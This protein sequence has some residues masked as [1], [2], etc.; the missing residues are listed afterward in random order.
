MKLYKKMP[1][2]VD[3]VI[4]TLYYHM[5]MNSLVS[6]VDSMYSNEIMNSVKYKEKK[7]NFINRIK[8]AEQKIFCICVDLYMIYFGNDYDEINKVLSTLKRK[9]LKI[10][11]TLTE[12]YKDLLKNPS[13]EQDYWS[14]TDQ[15]V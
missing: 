1:N 14:R 15:G 3:I 13:F 9:K 4:E 6:H 8:Y 10:K 11:N 2:F 12:Q 5:N 7:T